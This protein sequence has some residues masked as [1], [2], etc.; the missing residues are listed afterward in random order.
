MS[1][2]RRRCVHHTQLEWEGD[3]LKGG[4][5]DRGERGKSERDG[6]LGRL[7]R[8]YLE[9]LGWTQ[10]V[11]VSSLCNLDRSDLANDGL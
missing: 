5:R 2:R 1:F 9:A 11:V 8:K 7:M 6:R 4:K 10:P 3:R